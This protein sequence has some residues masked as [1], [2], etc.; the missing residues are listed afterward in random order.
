MGRSP[1]VVSSQDVMGPS[2]EAI[3]APVALTDE[4]SPSARDALLDQLIARAQAGDTKAFTAL[5]S[6]YDKKVLGIAWR[7][8]R[9][10]EDAMDAAQETFVR[11][12]KYLGSYDSSHDFGAWLYRIVVN[13]CLR[14]SAQRRPNTTAAS[15]HEQVEAP[16]ADATVLARDI[17][18]ALATLAPKERAALMLR[19]FDGLST[20]EVASILGASPAA[21]RV[22]ICTA[23]KKIRRFLDQPDNLKPTTST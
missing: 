13:V 10:R 17:E 19:D 9:N 8:M 5:M 21:I 14:M 11:L 3:L 20:E 16:Q 4:Q 23:R 2:I 22:H 7:H 12:Y 1:R 6:R 18:R 15:V